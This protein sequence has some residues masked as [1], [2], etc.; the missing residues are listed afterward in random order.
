ML[1]DAKD[2][3]KSGFSSEQIIAIFALVGVNALWGLS[4]PIIKSL[5][6]QMEHG[7]DLEGMAVSTSLHVAFTSGM[8]GLRFLIALA[9]VCLFCPQLVRLASREEWQAGIVVGLLFYFGLVL[10]VM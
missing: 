5:N 8:I 7:F 9:I 1:A 10:Q 3:S 2:P 6:Q 4:F